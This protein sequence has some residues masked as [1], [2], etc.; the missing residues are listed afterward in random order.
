MAYCRNFTAVNR[1]CWLAV[2]TLAVA[3]IALCAPSSTDAQGYDADVGLDP[4]HSYVDV[5]AAGGGIRE[6]EISLDIA[7]RVRERLEQRGL[8]VRMTR[9]D[10]GP[11]SAMN[12]PD[13]IQRVRI[14]QEARVAAVGRVRAYVSVHFHGHPS[15]SL[16]G[17]ET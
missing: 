8:S 1:L 14:E 3:G 12:H 6:F 15:P 9:T 11:L 5:G 13:S 16:R 10:A 7:Q 17:T 2:I 4:G